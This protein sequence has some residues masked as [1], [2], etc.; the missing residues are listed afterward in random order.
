MRWTAFTTRL[1][2]GTI[3][4]PLNPCDD[5]LATRRLTKAGLLS[6]APSEFLFRDQVRMD[7]FIDYFDAD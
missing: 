5:T 7:A 6:E 2:R 1:Q 4:P 3:E